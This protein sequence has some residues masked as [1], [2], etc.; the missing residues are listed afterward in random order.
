MVPSDLISLLFAN[1]INPK[2]DSR[3]NPNDIELCIVKSGFILAKE[4]RYLKLTGFVFH[5]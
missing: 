2:P 4:S 1:G 3:I 5:I